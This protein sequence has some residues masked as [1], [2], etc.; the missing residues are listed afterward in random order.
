[1][2]TVVFLVDEALL[3]TNK[4]SKSQWT[5]S[6]VGSQ[7]DSHLISHRFSMLARWLKWVE[8]EFTDQKVRGSNPTSASGLPLSR[9]G[10]P[11]SISAL[12]LPSGGMA[13]RHRKGVTAEQFSMLAR[14]NGWDLHVA[15]AQSSLVWRQGRDGANLLTERFVVRTQPLHPSGA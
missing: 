15:K 10:Q 6:S 1:M 3:L 4:T 8:R 5:L 2:L 14:R 7:I 9:L 12:V 13:A 11:D